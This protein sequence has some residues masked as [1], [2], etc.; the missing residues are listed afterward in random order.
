MDAN[1]THMISKILL[2]EDGK[3]LLLMSNKLNKYHLPGGHVQKNETFKQAIERELEEETGLKLS[4]CRVVFSKAN[5]YLFSGKPKNT[6]VK[7]SEEHKKFV[8]APIEKAHL[9]PLCDFTKKDIS[10]LQKIFLNKKKK[11][12]EVSEE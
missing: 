9:L 3:V 7:L 2:V 12:V 10:G 4:W 5:F 8:W 1:D 6:N 11:K